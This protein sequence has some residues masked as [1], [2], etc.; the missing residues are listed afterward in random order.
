MPVKSR[1]IVEPS[2]E[3]P[4]GSQ[5]GPRGQGFL[6]AVGEEIRRLRKQRDITLSQVAARSG[7]S[8]GA[9]SQLE[10]GLGNPGLELLARVAHALG[11]SVASL[12]ASGP[13]PSPVVRRNER[14][15]LTM[16]PGGR[17]E[18]TEGVFELLTPGLNHQLEVIWLEI[19]PGSSTDANPYV[20]AGEEVG[21]TIEGV[22]EVHVG[23]ETYLL[24]AGDAI[25]YPSTVPHWY[26]NPGSGVMRAI[27]IITPPTW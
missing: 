10:R 1:I 6:I 2:S 23:E 25:T 19:P 18:E 27:W 7:V 17:T 8:L 11:V 12:L 5:F 24:E 13:E 9:L 20:H 22:H 26:R 15:R 3:P 14:R 21:I 16:H 4:E